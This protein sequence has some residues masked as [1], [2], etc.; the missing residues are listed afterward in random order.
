VNLDLTDDEAAALPQLLRLTFDEDRYPLSPRLAP[1]RAILE[2]LDPTKPRPKLAAPPKGIHGALIHGTAPTAMNALSR[3][4]DDA[5]QGWVGNRPRRRRRPKLEHRILERTG[6]GR[7]DAKANGVKFGRK[8][9]LTP[10]QQQEARKRLEAG[11]TQRSVARSYN[12]GQSTISG[13]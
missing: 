10:H 1:L 4:A 7:A 3:A 12:V 2:K 5:R 11:E 8:P 13:L 6:C 9:T